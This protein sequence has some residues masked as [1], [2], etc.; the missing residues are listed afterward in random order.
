MASIF[1]GKAGR[2]AANETMKQAAQQVGILGDVY[3]QGAAATGKELK[4]GYTK[5]LADLKKYYPQS[6]DDITGAR[7]AAGNLLTEGRDASLGAVNTGY[8]TAIGDINQYYG[9]GA[10]TLQGAA[11][12][13][14]PLIDRAMTGYD[15]Y[16]NSLG[17]NGAEGTAAAQG[18]F[19]AGPGYQWNVDQATGQAQRAANRL[20]GAFGGNTVDATERLASNLANQEYGNWQKNLSGFQGAAERGVAGQ[21]GVLT[22]LANLYTNQGKD[23]SGLDVGRGKDQATIYSNAATALAGNQTTAGAAL[24]KLAQDQ[25]TN[26]ASLDTNYGQSQATNQANFANNMAGTWNNFFSTVIPSTQQ[27]MMAG[28]QAAANRTGAIMGGL[29]MAGQALGGFMGLPMA[30][31]GSIGGNLAGKIFG[32]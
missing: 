18:A 27:G 1:S 6:R 15:M 13:Y 32:G 11:A 31:G 29:Q 25:G 28:Q 3:T 30:G 21:T 20:G 22:N 8:D 24:S 2:K 4:S 19:Q 14:Q 12:G 5:S 16:N 26:L 17:L 23:L 10:E 7:D 9:Q